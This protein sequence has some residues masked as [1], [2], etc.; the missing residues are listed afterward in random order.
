V[1]GMP[2][3][4]GLGYFL[5]GPRSPM[6]ERVSAFGHPGAGGSIGFADPEY[7]LAVGFTKNMLRTALDPTQASAYRVGQKIREVLGIPSAEEVA[8]R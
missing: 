2:T 6:S 1:I 3:R 7:G 4:K 5:G 8:S